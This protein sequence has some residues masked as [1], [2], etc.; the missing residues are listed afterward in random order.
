M[1]GSIPDESTA[2]LVCRQILSSN[3]GSISR[4]SKD[5]DTNQWTGTCVAYK[6][7]LDGFVDGCRPILGLDGCFLKEKYGG[8]CLSIIGLDGNNGL[9]PI[10]VYL[11][12]HMY[13]NIKRYHRGTHLESLVWGVV[14]SS[15]KMKKNEKMD[16]LKADNPATYDWL[17]KEPY[18]HWAR[19]HFDFTFKCKHIANNFSESFNNWILKIRDKPVHRASEKLNLMLMKLMLVPRAVKHITKMETFYGNYHPEGAADGCFVVI[20]VNGQRWRVNT[21]KH[22]CDCNEWQLTGLP[23]VHVPNDDWL[24]PPLVRGS[25]RPRKVRLVDT[26][27]TPGV[28]KKCGKYG[29]FGYDK[30]TCKGVPALLRP[31]VPRHKLRV[32]THSS[33]AKLKRNTIQ[34]PITPSVSGRDGS[35]GSSTNKARGIKGVGVHYNNY[36]GVI[37]IGI[38]LFGGGVAVRGGPSG[39]RA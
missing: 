13:K 32:D 24:P 27:E 15:K 8:V 17:A 39:G 16:K 9:F 23:C 2:P 21:E 35:A 37:G 33:R 10:A 36:G 19:S 18:E 12:R 7:S 34:P 11:C 20:A 14:K 3:P 22:E 6:I 28:Q 38:D 4:T 25:G 26:N 5:I 1:G 31:S 30:K 29:G